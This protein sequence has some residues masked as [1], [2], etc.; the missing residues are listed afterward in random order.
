M[1]LFSN[2]E[3]PGPGI[4]KNAPRTKGIKLFFELYFRKIGSY[5]QLNLFYLTSLI[6]AI[7][8]MWYIIMIVINDF[9][10]TG[11][12][13]LI[14][15]SFLSLILSIAVC[16]AFGLS[17]FSSGFH[18]V[19]RNFSFEKHAFVFSDF[20]DKFREN[21]KNSWIMFIVDLVVVIISTL[22][23]RIYLIMSLSNLILIV[24]LVL[25]VLIMIVYSLMT[26]YKWTM[27][28][29]FNLTKKQIYKNA[30][31]LVLG[32]GKTTLKHFV[33]TS[34]II[35]LCILLVYL[36]PLLGI[37]LFVLTGAS[38]FGLVA[39]LNIYKQIQDLI[40]Q[41]PGGHDNIK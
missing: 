34:L 38:V 4:N 21:S 1:G 7:A 9:A 3:K 30:L 17:P 36:I 41:S 12:D 10:Q 2:F 22:L 31:F 28:I 27:L 35:A 32:D 20:I 14:A 33:A 5:I 6:P 23:L 8:I 40:S 13:T 16:T 18:Y 11:N 24:P 25:I 19:L 37:I 29:T 15:L 26:P 39:Q